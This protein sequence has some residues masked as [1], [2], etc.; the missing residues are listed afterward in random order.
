[1]VLVCGVV[2]S[3]LLVGLVRELTELELI[4][5]PQYKNWAVL[6]KDRPSDDTTLACGLS[7]Q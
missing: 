6:G 2:I 4:E 3:K 5:T 7:L 1:V